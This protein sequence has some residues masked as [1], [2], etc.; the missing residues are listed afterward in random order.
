MPK[1]IDHRIA[2]GQLCVFQCLPQLTGGHLVDLS[3]KILCALQRKAGETG[4]IFVGVRR[5]GG[6]LRF[7]PHPV[8]VAAILVI[9]VVAHFVRCFPANPFPHHVAGL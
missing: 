2:G 3:L 5:H 1:Q 9:A 4:W 7:L 6:R 8:T